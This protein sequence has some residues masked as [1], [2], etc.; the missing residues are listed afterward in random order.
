M[1][2]YELKCDTIFEEMLVEFPHSSMLVQLFAQYTVEIKNDEAMSHKL[3]EIS[4]SMG[5][6]DEV[7]HMAQHLQERAFTLTELGKVVQ[8][9]FKLALVPMPHSSRHRI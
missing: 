6:K 5:D 4:D 3:D 8:Y 9:H 7:S 2:E 1:R